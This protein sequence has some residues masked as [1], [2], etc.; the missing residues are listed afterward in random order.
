M[1]FVINR[2]TNAFLAFA[3]AK[4]T[5]KIYFILNLVLCNE[6]LKF[7][8]YLARAFDVARASDA[9]RYFYHC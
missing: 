1:E 6:L 3:E 2:Y 7:F 9:Y 8:Y 5:A 4:R